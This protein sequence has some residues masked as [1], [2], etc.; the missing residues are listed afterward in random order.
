MSEKVIS[1]KVIGSANPIAK[2]FR[3]IKNAFAGIGV[4]IVLLILGLFLIFQSVY[5]VKENS[6]LVASLALTK[7]TEATVSDSDLIKLQGKPVN[8]T[9]VKY[10]YEKCV[11]R[12]CY[13]WQNTKESLPQA[14]Y[15]KVEKQRFEV[16][17][18]VRTETRTTEFA[19]Q[20]TEETV[21]ITEYKEEWVTKDTI[22]QW[23]N[24]N[25][26][27]ILVEPSDNTKLMTNNTSAEVANIKI[28]NLGEL[29]NYGQEASSEV[30]ATRLVYTYLPYTTESTDFLVVGKLANKTVASGEPFIV[31]DKSEDQLV[32]AL[33]DEENL[34]RAGFAFF[35]WL[36]VFIGLSMLLAPILEFV[37]WIPLAGKLAKF[38]AGLIALITATI[39][40][41]ASWLILKFWWL[42]LIV[43][44][45]LI[46]AAV[47]LV[48]KMAAKKPEATATV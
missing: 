1:S 23:A 45:V 44:I 26:G 2:K 3:S 28:D 21:E 6:K 32:K 17:K 39:L 5:G 14:L 33:E 11:T 43:V 27:S 19:G 48:V 9:P 20:E 36:S 10:E 38:V 42:I 4:G 25:M 8:V 31:T 35:S 13:S 22:K 47:F 18:H 24:F 41:A 46:A 30:G 34:A 16:V 37:S 7:A 15:L 12:D 40:V 29:N